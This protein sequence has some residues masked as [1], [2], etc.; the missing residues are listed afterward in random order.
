MSAR[1]RYPPISDYAFLSDCHSSALVSTTASIDWCC[2][3]RFDS[4]SCFGRL[5]DWRR[6]GFC[7]IEPVDGRIVGRDYLDRSL[8][9]ATDFREGGSEARLLDCFTLRRG[10]ALTPHGQ[11]VRV[12]EGRRGEIRMRLRVAPRFDYGGVRPWIRREG[13]NLFSAIGG[14][15]ALVISCDAQLELEGEHDLVAEFPVRAGER[16]RLSLVY[17]RPEEVDRSE[18]TAADPEE[19]D[20][21]IDTTRRMWR[22]W[23]DNATVEGPEASG[24][25]RSALVLKGLSNAPTGAIAAAATTSLP[26]A[27]GAGRTWDYRYS[28]IR[29]SVFSVRSLAAAGLERE[30]DGFRRFIQRTS[31]GHVEDLQIV[32]G[33]GGERRIGEQEIDALEG[34]R[35]VGPVRAGNGAVGQTQL[36]AYGEIVSLAW[37][38][39]NRG[40]SPDDDLW[41]FITSICDAAAKRWREPDAGLWEWRG[42]PLHF[43]YSKV[44]CWTALDRGLALAGECLREA[45]ERRWK[46]ARAQI[47]RAVESDG[48]DKRRGVF[49][50]VF[51]RNLVDAALLLLPRAGF[52]EYRDERMVR[53]ADVV[54]KDLDDDG[55]IRRYGLRDGQPG[56]E[57]AFLACSFWLVECLAQQGR[58][59]EARE[60]YERAVAARSDLGLY[61]EEFDTRRGEP[62][63]NYPQAL[64]HLGHIEAAMA[65][66]AAERDLAL[67][68]G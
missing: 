54:A 66:T 24:I 40:N 3:P 26:E 57:G 44:M 21:R 47:R 9:L 42:R 29:D 20:R 63:G 48:Y 64:T 37:R 28:W 38:W 46:R 49:R 55:L 33:L 35:G 30:A 1:T 41:R 56:R 31:A 67:S 32:Y 23:A 6:G 15:D 11:L 65:L 50:Q 43:T 62:C 10:G 59:E 39:H 12:I 18:P 58:I 45:P 5:L 14:N 53:T 68:P 4:G 61:S 17:S 19:T 13:T 34:Y 2:M 36:D 7:T 27:L 51:G 52:V 22:R 8:V 60:R 16:V 25:V